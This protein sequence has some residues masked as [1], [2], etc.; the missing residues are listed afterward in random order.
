MTPRRLA[1]LL[2]VVVSSLALMGVSQWL[3]AAGMS[4][5]QAETLARQGWKQADALRGQKKYEQ[6]AKVYEKTLEI[7]TE[8]KQETT[9]LGMAAKQMV[10]FCKAMPIDVKTLKD[11]AYEGTAWGYCGEMTI[12]VTLKGGKMTRFEIKSHKESRKPGLEKV[13]GFIMARQHPSVDSVTNCTVTAYGLMTATLR[14][15][16]K[17]P[18]AEKPADKPADKPKDK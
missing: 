13:P 12:A 7:L 8:A 16:Q 11:G 1:L 18:Q 17:A 3:P 4:H 9:T 6:A 2:V 14:A 10:E 15:L 5:G